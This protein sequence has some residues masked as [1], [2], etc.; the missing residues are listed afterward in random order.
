MPGGGKLTIETANVRRSTRRTARAHRGCGRGVRAARRERHRARDDRRGEAPPLRAVLHDQGRRARHRARSRHHLRRRQAGR[1]LDRGRTPR[2]AVER[3]FKIY[4]PAVDGQPALLEPAAREWPRAGRRCSS[5]RTT[6][7]ARLG[8]KPAGGHRITRP[9]R[10]AGLLAAVDTGHG[11]TPVGSGDA[12]AARREPGWQS[13]TSGPG[14][15]EARSTR[16]SPP[17]RP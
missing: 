7:P 11:L 15:K 5:S 10:P 6:R 14:T 9:S 16:G 1:R 17:I 2:S 4:L 8:P 13:A 12:G 3:R